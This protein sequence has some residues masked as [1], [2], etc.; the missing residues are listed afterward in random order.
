MTESRTRL[1]PVAS[2]VLFVALAVTLVPLAYLFSVSL[3][4]RDETVSGVLWSAAPHWENWGD[5]LSTDIPRSTMSGWSEAGRV[6]GSST[7][8]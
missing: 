3:M 8:P 1:R 4:G 5:V 7:A 6:M 2:S